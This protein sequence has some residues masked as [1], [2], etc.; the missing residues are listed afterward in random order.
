MI[1]VMQAGAPEEELQQVLRR[2]EQLGYHPHLIRGTQRN[3]V[4]AVVDELGK[5]RLKSLEALPGVESVVRILQPFKLASREFRPKTVVKIGEVEIGSDRLVLM[6]GAC[7]GGR[8]GLIPEGAHAV[9]RRG[10][11]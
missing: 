5:A 3:V 2:V 11:P 7:S 9:K 4:G 6:A 1:I 8:E 10:G